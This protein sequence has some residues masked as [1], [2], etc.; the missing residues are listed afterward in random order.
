MEELDPA[1]LGMD[2]KQPANSPPCVE[3]SSVVDPT[4][5]A[6]MEIFT[7]SHSDGY[8]PMPFYQ[9]FKEEIRLW[10]SESRERMAWYTYDWANSMFA[11]MAVTFFMPLL[12]ASMAKTAAFKGNLIPT[13]S[14]C[15]S[16]SCP[17]SVASCQMC[18]MGEGDKY[19]NASSQEWTDLPTRTIAW[20][21][22]NVDA[23]QFATRVVSYS[24]IL[25]L[26]IFIT[27][28]AIADYERY[29]YV[30]FLGFIIVGSISCMLLISVTS[31]SLYV[32][33]GALV[34]ISN[35]CWGAANVL[36][37]SY[38]PLIVADHKEVVAA[39]GNH[40][41]WEDIENFMSSLGFMMGY[42][43]GIISTIA[44]LILVSVIANQEVAYKINI[45][46]AGA[47]WAVFSVVTLRG[48]KVRKGKSSTGERFL[49]FRGWYSTFNSFVHAAQYPETFKFFL[50]WFFYSDSYSTVAQVGVLLAQQQLCMPGSKLA[51]ILVFTMIFALFGNMFFLWLQQRWAIGSKAIVTINL[52]GYIV[53]CVIGMMGFIPGS[54]VGFKTDTEAYVFALIHGFMVGS[55]QSF[56]RTI[57]SDLSVPGRESEFFALFEITNKGSSWLGPL[58][59][60]ELYRANGNMNYGFL[61]LFLMIVL[62]MFLFWSVKHE[63]GMRDVGR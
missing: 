33:A 45:F 19:W 39:N 10:G 51:F 47:W 2:G 61:Y 41:V 63:K 37:N 5:H 12:L 22:G 29:R 36:Y 11:A 15:T 25:Q 44:A 8:K 4:A 53:I 24:V 9:R 6:I 59:V 40:D 35:A 43:S 23:F 56:S 28:G 1:P 55:L 38:L 18:I 14:N 60:G 57:C 62:P 21:P 3:E 20:W 31:S 58:I 26:I 13:C 54:K 46:I 27:I 49:I 32:Y 42:V 48:L 16:Y 30:F 17:Q 50:A 34:I 7:H 52:F